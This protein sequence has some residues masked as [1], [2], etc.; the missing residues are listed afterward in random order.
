MIYDISAQYHINYHII[1]LSFI[2]DRISI[3]FG[4]KVDSVVKKNA[5]LLNCYGMFYTQRAVVTLNLSTN[6]DTF[7]VETKSQ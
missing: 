3:I 5:Y 6:A 2:Y 1:M 4:C 7:Y